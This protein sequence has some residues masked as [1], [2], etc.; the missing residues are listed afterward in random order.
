MT[1]LVPQDIVL[2]GVEIDRAMLLLHC[3]CWDDEITKKKEESD[4]KQNFNTEQDKDTQRKEEETAELTT[5]MP[6]EQTQHEQQQSQPE[7]T[8]PT[9]EQNG[10]VVTAGATVGATADVPRGFTTLSGVRGKLVPSGRTS[11]I[12]LDHTTLTIP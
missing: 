5:P 4:V 12:V 7:A 9:T 11:S 3:I 2:E 1:L 8:T 10:S 6:T